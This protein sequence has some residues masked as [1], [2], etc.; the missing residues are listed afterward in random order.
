MITLR[1]P[2]IVAEAGRILAIPARDPKTLLKQALISLALIGLVFA[3]PAFIL[4][5]GPLF[6][7][8]NQEMCHDL[9]VGNLWH[10]FVLGCGVVL[11]VL[12]PRTMGVRIGRI[13]AHLGLIASVSV[14]AFATSALGA[15][16]LTE[17][18]FS[19]APPGLYLM[20]PIG[21]EL[22]FRGFAYTLLLW[23]FPTQKTRHGLSYAV[24]GSALLFGLW[25]LAMQGTV[26][27]GFIWVQA[28]YTA[29]AGLLLGLLREKT[30]SLLPCVTT[31]MGSNLVVA[32]I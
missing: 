15:W 24:I 22:I 26:T 27:V 21:E 31:H 13:R 9:G 28:G 32:L 19:D 18:P 12:T 23:A 3:L 2:A 30:G 1:Q 8:A 29:L 4:W 5:C 16:F 10:M 20:T 25:H 11:V 14:I 7:L 6:Y 17:N